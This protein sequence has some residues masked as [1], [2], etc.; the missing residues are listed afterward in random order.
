MFDN[1]LA[2]ISDFFGKMLSLLKEHGFW[3]FI[4]IIVITIVLLLTLFA[5]FYFANYMVEERRARQQIEEHDYQ[6][7]IRKAIQPKINSLLQET[8]VAL[9][10]DRVCILELH[11]GTNNTA[12]LPFIHASMTYEEDGFD[13]E[14]IDEDYQ[15]LTLSRFY[16]PLYLHKN[17]YWLGNISELQEVDA[18][19]AKRMSNNDAKFLAICTL[20]SEDLE[21]GYFAITFCK[22]ENIPSSRAI[23]T[24][25]I[26]VSQQVSKLLEKSN[27]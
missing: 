12:G 19:L 4:K 1:I 24:K 15:N 7:G 14:S 10:A 26:A 21:L 8:R 13:V 3:S 23:I 16:F 6:I 22:N 2:K 11:N 5:T 25:M 27:L 9:G 17:N 20:Y 18:K